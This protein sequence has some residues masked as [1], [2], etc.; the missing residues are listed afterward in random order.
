MACQP[1]QSRLIYF[2]LCNP[3][4]RA[5]W[6]SSS[7]QRQTDVPLALPVETGALTAVGC[8]GCLGEEK[9]FSS[10]TTNGF[11]KVGVTNIVCASY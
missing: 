4:C 2:N 3:S 5:M 7:R 8:A 10:D 9:F 1:R 6:S 11:N